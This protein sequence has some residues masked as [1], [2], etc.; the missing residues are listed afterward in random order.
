MRVFR[1]YFLQ[2]VSKMKCKDK[3]YDFKIKS[4]WVESFIMPL[5]QISSLRYKYFSI[6]KLSSFSALQERGDWKQSS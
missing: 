4:L 6:K 3:K 5:I 1:A 2:L